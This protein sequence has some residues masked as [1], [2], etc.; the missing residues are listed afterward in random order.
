MI[1]SLKPSYTK[2]DIV[3]IYCVNLYG[4]KFTLIEHA[5]SFPFFIQQIQHLVSSV[6]VTSMHRTGK[7]M[8][9]TICEDHIIFSQA[10]FN[11]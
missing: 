8:T 1:Y 11:H 10:Y 4:H 7:L 2:L 5:N 3:L 6:I 9:R